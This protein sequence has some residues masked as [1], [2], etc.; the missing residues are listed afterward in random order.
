MPPKSPDSTILHSENHDCTLTNFNYFAELGATLVL[1][2]ETTLREIRLTLHRGKVTRE[3]ALDTGEPN[4]IVAEAT[5]VKCGESTYC[6]VHRFVKKEN[7]RK[8]LATLLLKESIN[9]LQK[10]IPNLKITLSAAQEDVIFW[11]LKNGFQ[12]ESE[13]D[14]NKL[15]RINRF[16]RGDHHKELKRQ[17]VY[18]GT[19]E[20]IYFFEEN[21]EARS[22]YC[23]FRTKFVLSP[24][25][26]ESA[27]AIQKTTNASVNSIVLAR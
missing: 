17:K 4:S 12:P 7:R 3:N 6:L 9:F 23:A 5:L 2:T 24:P 16:L 20:E 19:A 18:N 11:A 14:I 15:D 10:F 25:S 8:A 21:V 22:P 13:D 26:V 27:T 1:H